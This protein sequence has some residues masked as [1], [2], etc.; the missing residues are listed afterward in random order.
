MNWQKNKPTR[1]HDSGKMDKEHA[2]Q[3]RANA[4]SQQTFEK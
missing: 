1:K 4:D 3:L 2:T